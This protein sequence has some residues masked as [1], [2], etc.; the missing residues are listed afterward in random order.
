MS[1]RDGVCDV[2][3]SKPSEADKVKRMRYH[4]QIILAY[5]SKHLKYMEQ[6]KK[7]PLVSIVTPSYNQARYLEATIQSVLCQRYTRI[8]YIVIDGGSSDG[9]QKI[10]QQ[11]ADRLAYW[12]SGPDEGQTEAINKGF[13]HAK[14]EIF[15]WVNSDDLLRPHAVAEAVQYLRD[16]P[17]VGMVYGDAD[18]INEDGEVIGLFPA[19][20]T[21]YKRLRQGYVHIPQQAAFFR[22]H[23]WRMAGPLD[24]SFYFAMDYDLWVRIAALS[25]I[26]YYPRTWAAFRIHDAAKTLK[27]ADRCWPEMIRVHQRLGGGRISVIYAKFLI[28]RLLEPILPFRLHARIWLQRWAKGRSQ[29]E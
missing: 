14:G 29:V 26:H 28:R 7:L 17:H 4:C 8:E 16:N 3:S 6:S 19:S 20:Q 21:D 12:T 25:P 10:I 27:T 15:G 1:H 13:A 22:A 18:Y 2:N 23:L 24:P 9:S 5:R 11:Y